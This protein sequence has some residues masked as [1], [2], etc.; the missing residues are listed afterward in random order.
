MDSNF[1]EAV[2]TD[3][4]AAGMEVPSAVKSLTR[5]RLISFSVEDAWVTCGQDQRVFDDFVSTTALGLAKAYGIH[6]PDTET[7]KETLRKK[8]EPL[9]QEQRADRFIQ[10]LGAGLGAMPNYAPMPPELIAAYNAERKCADKSSICYAPARSV[11]FGRD[12]FAS[13]CCYTRSRP[14]GKYPED[15]VDEIWFGEKIQTMRD[16]LARNIL[17]ASCGKCADQLRAKNY[18][19]LLAA[20]FD[21]FAVRPTEAQ[22]SALKRFF[23]LE[24]A[25][26]KAD[27]DAKEYPL[28]MEFELSNKCNLECTMCSGF[29]SSSIRANREKLPSLAQ[30]YDSNFV[31]QLRPYIPHLKVAKF[32]GGEPFLIDLYYEIWELFIELNP[33]CLI[34][35]TCNGTVFTNKVQRIVDKLN[36]RITVSFDSIDKINYERIRKNATLEST[37]ANIDKFTAVNRKYGREMSLNICPMVSNWHGIPDI[38]SYA[39]DRGLVV[40]FTTVTFPEKE[41][42]KFL[43]AEEHTKVIEGLRSAIGTPKN[44]IETRNFRTLTNLCQQVETW[45]KEARIPEL[46]V[47]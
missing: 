29:F 44:E 19:G 43:P 18:R 5:E 24:K 40:Y 27:P 42:L 36:C 10:V 26:P 34:L 2:T 3:Q 17:P 46:V 22:P 8:L 1:D 45:S 21:Q 35:I 31:E 47:L 15:T 39:N 14:L 7:A 20:T 11:Y 6:M 9:F 32:Y 33:T 28:C 13:A 30:L 37:L 16:Q 38:V 4:A 23:G 41:S 12:G 25:V